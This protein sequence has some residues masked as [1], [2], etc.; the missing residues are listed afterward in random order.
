M[1]LNV[2]TLAKQLMAEALLHTVQAGQLR[3]AARALMGEPAVL[4]SKR[5]REGKGKSKRGKR[6]ISRAGRARIAAAQRKR[7]AQLRQEKREK[8]SA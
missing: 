3:N 5:K 6:H 4:Q 8:K 7:W 1:K 2:A